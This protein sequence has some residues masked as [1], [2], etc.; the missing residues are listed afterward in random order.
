MMEDIFRRLGRYILLAHVKD[1][2]A[3]ADEGTYL[4]AAG[5]S[6]LDYPLYLRLL[7]QL[8][9]EIY[10]AIDPLHWK[11]AAGQ[12]LYTQHV[13]ANLTLQAVRIHFCGGR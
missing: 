11:R 5:L 9:P 8:D 4:P 1:V 7:A 12:R 6:V 2:K 3:A 10:I 13:R